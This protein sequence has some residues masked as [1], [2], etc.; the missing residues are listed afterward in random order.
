M[1]WAGVIVNG[2]AVRVEYPAASE[3]IAMRREKTRFAS[4]LTF[5]RGEREEGG[6]EVEKDEGGED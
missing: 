5:R 1:K 2:F 6:V 4:W 3:K